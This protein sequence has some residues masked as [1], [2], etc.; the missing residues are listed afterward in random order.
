VRNKWQVNGAAVSGMRVLA[1]DDIYTTGGTVHSFACELRQ[2]GA[3]SVHAV[4]LA[5]NLW[6]PHMASGMSFVAAV[7]RR[8]LLDALSQ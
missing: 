6:A 2:A 7:R 4:V 5:R 1:L 3:A 8:R